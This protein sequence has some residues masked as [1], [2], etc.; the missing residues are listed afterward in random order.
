V[1]EGLPQAPQGLIGL[2]QGSNFGKV[3]V[4]VADA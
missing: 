3:V 4:R 2:L 1:L